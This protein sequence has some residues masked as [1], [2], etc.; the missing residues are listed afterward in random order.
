MLSRSDRF[1]RRFIAVIGI[2]LFLGGAA[3][4]AFSAVPYDF[5]KSKADLLAASGSSTLLTG[6]L[7]EQI[8]LRLK[9]FGAAALSGVFLLYVMRKRAAGY[10][11]DVADS[12]RG[13]IAGVK[14]Y[15]FVQVMRKEAVFHIALLL[16]ILT[17]ALIRIYFLNQPIK[18]DEAGSFLYSTARPSFMI[19]SYYVTP[20]NHI[21]HTLLM[22]CSYL[23]FGG[24]L[25]A[26]RLPAFVF[27]VLLI[28]AS[29][30]VM[31][32]LTNVQAALFTAALTA[33]STF[34][35]EYS[36]N[37]RGYTMMFFFF[38][39]I[40]Y[41]GTY[42]TRGGGSFTWLLLAIFASLG[43]YT[44]PVMLYPFSIVIC[45][46]LLSIL[47]NKEREQRLQDLKKLFTGLLIT[48][49]MTLFLYL[50]VLIVSGWEAV[51]ANPFVLPQSWDILRTLWLNTTAALW[52][53]INMETPLLLQIVL[54]ASILICVF[55][56]RKLNLLLLSAMIAPLP[57]LLV[58][59]VAPPP[60]VWIFWAF[61]YFMAAAAGLGYLISQSRLQ[62]FR[63]AGHIYAIIMVSLAAVL[64]I[65]VSNSAAIGWANETG[66]LRDGAEIVEA[67]APLLGEG[68]CILA[69]P[70]SDAVLEYYLQRKG[71]PGDYL[72]GDPRSSKRVFVLVNESYSHTLYEILE[73]WGLGGGYCS[74]PRIRCSCRGATLYE[75]DK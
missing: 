60:R 13:A 44:I 72:W 68:D 55:F 23:I 66:T 58:Q 34:L 28:P 51:A 10:L 67:L 43:L 31:R 3:M 8:G 14:K 1:I 30:A 53:Q 71:L 9:L 19:A 46:L 57:F 6:V 70:P 56:Y 37:G 73:D 4:A 33:S 50:P 25:W 64:C 45:W 39:C 48:F 7:Y 59:R 42:L 61:I 75:I 27:G 16:L 24:S 18:F 32:R 74:V 36:T 15:P 47:Q 21:L 41:L 49:F 69:P 63:Y 26:I 29:Y 11:Q 40:L 35:I 62:K 2:L 38:L 5:L 17:A 65:Q 20:N 54:A 52:G 22:R 12:A